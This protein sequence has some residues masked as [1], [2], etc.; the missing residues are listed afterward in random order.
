MKIDLGN[1]DDYIDQL[2]NAARLKLAAAVRRT[3]HYILGMRDGSCY[4]Y[5]DAIEEA[6]REVLAFHEREDKKRTEYQDGVQE[7][8]EETKRIIRL[9]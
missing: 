4:M 6:R 3:T 2:D 7:R 9:T 8:Y 1:V 5:K